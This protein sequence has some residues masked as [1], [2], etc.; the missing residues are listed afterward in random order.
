M[1]KQ[2]SDFGRRTMFHRGFGDGAKMVAI[3]YRDDPDY[4]EGYRYGGAARQRAVLAFCERH[5]VAPP[6][7]LRT[8]KTGS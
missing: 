8:Q 5:G 7:I 2:T 1:T 3:K 4:N 6:N